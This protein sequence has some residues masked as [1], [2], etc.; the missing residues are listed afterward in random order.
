[1]FGGSLNWNDPKAPIWT[2][3]VSIVKRNTLGMR[4]VWD[5]GI[6]G[7]SIQTF[8]IYFIFKNISNLQIRFEINPN[9]SHVFLF[10]IFFY[11]CIFFY[12]L[13]LRFVRTSSTPIQTCHVFIV[14]KSHGR[15]CLL[16]NNKMRFSCLLAI[17]QR[18]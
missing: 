10:D 13:N 6:Q 7:S 2:C 8:L 15:R 18:N 1:M 11:F 16:T 14:K 5:K 17:N 4:E 12:F 3:Y 9:F